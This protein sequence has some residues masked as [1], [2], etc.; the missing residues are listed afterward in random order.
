MHGFLDVLLHCYLNK[1]GHWSAVC[2]NSDVC[3]T[4]AQNSSV[5]E[6]GRIWQAQA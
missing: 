3:Y 1:D 6:V 5:G 4:F 2:L